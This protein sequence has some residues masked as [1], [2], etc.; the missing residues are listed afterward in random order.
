M[1]HCLEGR[2]NT[3]HLMGDK[4]AFIQ[5]VRD[6]YGLTIQTQQ[7][8]KKP[9]TEP[10]VIWLCSEGRNHFPFHR[11]LSPTPLSSLGTWTHDWQTW[12]PHHSPNVLFTTEKW[13]LGLSEQCQTSVDEAG[14][15]WPLVENNSVVQ[16]H[17]LVTFICEVEVPQGCRIKARQWAKYLLLMVCGL[18]QS[19]GHNFSGPHAKQG[20]VAC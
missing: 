8:F 20:C 12:S 10:T 1:G 14:P 2:Q 6:N 16:S 7:M 17:R 3:A 11:I 19:H 9:H 13:G 5:W 4:I 15:L 18:E